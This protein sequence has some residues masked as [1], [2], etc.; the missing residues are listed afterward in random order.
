MT[1]A[2]WNIIITF[3]IN[4]KQ[5]YINNSFKI[6]FKTNKSNLMKRMNY[7]VQDF[8]KIS[9]T[10]DNAVEYINLNAIAISYI[11][12]KQMHL[13]KLETKSISLESFFKF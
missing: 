4:S 9:S 5:E 1:I 11:L 6:V 10:F 8:T 3:L 7:S 12:V 13:E 2:V